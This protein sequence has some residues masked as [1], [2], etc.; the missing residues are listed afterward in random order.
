M[1]KRHPSLYEA[2]T[3]MD[4]RRDGTDPPV[5]TVEPAPDG[6]NLAVRIVIGRDERRNLSIQLSEDDA[7]DFGAAVI[8]IARGAT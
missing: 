5:I 4:G 8:A 7:L 2:R 1:K 3:K 6:S